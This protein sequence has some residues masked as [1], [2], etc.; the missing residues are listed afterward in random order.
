MTPFGLDYCWLTAESPAQDRL[1]T[2]R[3]QWSFIAAMLKLSRAG[4]GDTRFLE[5]P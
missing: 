1:G 2:Y 5:I 4:A 3:V